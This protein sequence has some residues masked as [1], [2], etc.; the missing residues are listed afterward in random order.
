[1]ELAA[2][3]HRSTDQFCYP[4]NDDELIINIQTGYDVDRVFL[5]EGDPYLAGIMGGKEKWAGERMEIYY[6]KRLKN[7]IWWTTTVRP[8]YKRSKYYFELHSGDEVL[9]YF[10]DGFYTEEEMNHEGK[11]LALFQFPWMN[12]ADIFRTPDWVNETIW[13]QIFPERF[14]NGDKSNDPEGVRPWKSEKIT[15]HRAYYGGD[16]QGIIDKVP[17]LRDLGITGL[18]LTPIF[19]AN[20]NHKYNTKDYRKVD[21]A[22]GTNE[23]LRQLVDICHGAG[24]RVM[25]DGVFNHTGT[26]IPMWQDVMEKGQDSE[27]ADWY[28][29]NEWP[30]TLGH[31][32]KDG[33]FYSFAFSDQMPKLD[34]N[35]PAVQQYLLD[36]VQFWMEEFDIDG[37]RL[38]VGNEI[39]H[40]FLKQLRYMTKAKKPDFYFL[41]EI[42]HD[43]MDWL[44]GDEY[45]AVMNYP[46]STAIN[47]FWVFDDW[48]KEEFEYA[49]NKSFTTY[50]QQANDVLFNLLDSHD[51]DRLMHRLGNDLDVFYQQ[52]AVLY[53]MPGSPCVFYGTEIAMEGAHDPDCRRCMPW[54]E[55]EAGLYDERINELRQLI[56][57]RKQ[58]PAFRSRNF[59][60]PNEVEDPRVIE[61][62]KLCD[63]EVVRIVLNCGNNAVDVPV[64]VDKVLYRRKYEQGVLLPKGIL[65]YSE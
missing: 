1:M 58:H 53:A 62:M 19:E 43:S 7:H 63:E 37:L 18:Y 6:K 28:M 61:F 17:Y 42:W 27:C 46:L 32:T 9:Y 4:L 13:Y 44:R 65:I 59:H 29:I 64:N 15:D 3:Y 60:F 8:Q 20:S 2:I 39:S 22:F 25:L 16:L 31:S 50:M 21:P 23:T 26:D 47:N 57:L 10:E 14:C 54:D 36:I 55:I 5:Y 51:T 56:A 33:R 35:H 48:K 24:I 11:S 52:L 34:T 45:D 12:G 40:R 49:I 38:D 30:V 41:G